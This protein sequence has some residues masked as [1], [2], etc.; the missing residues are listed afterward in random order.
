MRALAGWIPCLRS[1]IDRRSSDSSPMRRGSKS[2]DRR[3]Q[4]RTVLRE[5]M[6]N[7][8]ESRTTRTNLDHYNKAAHTDIDARLKRLGRS[9]NWLGQM[10]EANGIACLAAITHWG[11]GRVK[12]VGCGVYRALCDILT[13]EE[14]RMKEPVRIPEAK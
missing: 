2:G 8:R 11:N 9:W 10:A 7:K 13:A 6:S 1:V 4:K 14:R 3:P 5:N 12:Q